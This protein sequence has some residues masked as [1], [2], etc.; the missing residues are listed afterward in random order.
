MAETGLIIPALATVVDRVRGDI[1]SSLPGADSRLRRTAL[2]ALSL[3]LGG[4][5]WLLHKF[6]G[7]IA[8]ETLPDCASET[9][10]RRWQSMFGLPD[11]QPQR[12]AGAV[13]VTGVDGSG[14][15]VND[16]LV[17]NDGVL[18]DVTTGVTIAGGVGTVAVRAVDPGVIADAV[19]G[20]ALTFVIPLAGIDTLALVATGGLTG[21]VDDE[22]LSNRRGRVL[23]RMADPPQGGSDPDFVQWTKEA[24]VNVRTVYVS[25]NTPFFGFVT[26]RFIVEPLDG[27][28]AN[29]L[30]SAGQVQAALGY[31]AGTLANDFKD[32]KA[33]VPIAKPLTGT[34][35]QV[36]G[37]IDYRLL[38]AQ[39]ITM[40]VTALDPDTPEVRTAIANS[41]KGMLLQ[42]AEPGGTIKH[43]QFAGAIDAAPGEDSHDLGALLINGIPA[44]DVVIG[45]D[46]FPTLTTP[47][48]YV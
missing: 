48:T 11:I 45:A 25:R 4:V 5:S 12:S 15:A 9:G 33:P 3:G 41:V 46:S 39:P 42:K 44:D 19:A 7:E 23:D 27:D 37:R 17:R 43:S 47:L 16:Q 35:A 36:D 22:S 26:V 18:Y 20:Q 21:G 28:P 32:G 38:T 13:D 10:V 40:A 34:D 2:G 14:V 30:P 1:D 31:V 6:A 8:K 24:V 29:A